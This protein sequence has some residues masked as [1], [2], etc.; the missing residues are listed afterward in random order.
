[1]SQEEL[2]GSARTLGT[3]ESLARSFAQKEPGF[4]IENG[5]G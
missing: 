1:M 3:P 4:I 2:D 5:A